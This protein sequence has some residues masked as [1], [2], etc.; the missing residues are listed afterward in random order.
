MTEAE[1]NVAKNTTGARLPDLELSN[2]LVRLI[3]Q[4]CTSRHFLSKFFSCLCREFEI[5]SAVVALFDIKTQAVLNLWQHG[6]QASETQNTLGTQTYLRDPIVNK[7]LQSAPGRFYATNLDLPNWRENADDSVLEWSKQTGIVEAAGAML[8]L[9]EEVVLTVFFQKADNQT[10]FTRSDLAV[11]DPLLADLAEACKLVLQFT[12]VQKQSPHQRA[13]LEC[14]PF[15]GMILDRH[16]RIHELNSEAEHWLAGSRHVHQVNNCFRLLN[17]KLQNRL[18]VDSA[19]FM[20]NEFETR[21]MNST[22]FQLENQE[23]S[24]RMSYG[25][26]HK[27][28]ILGDSARPLKLILKKLEQQT[29]DDTSHDCFLCLAFPEELDRAPSVESLKQVFR[30]SQQEARI[31]RLLTTGLPLP[32]IAGE[33]ELSVHTVRDSLKKRIFKK[34]QCH[35]QN[36]LIAKVLTSPAMYIQSGTLNLGQM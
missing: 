33:L 18:S 12:E 5:R 31:V 1:I 32:Q 2:Q 11:F 21:D 17:P 34:C 10:L 9:T 6:N 19:D 30:L 25:E 28:I 29:D 4:S 13:L 3:Y 14:F 24:T 16:L 26:D 23:L 15:P 36:K 20:S 8:P 27:I 7:V 22:N 35:S